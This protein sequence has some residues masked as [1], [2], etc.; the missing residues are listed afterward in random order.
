MI[1]GASP[2]AGSSLASRRMLSIRT[3]TPLYAGGF[4]GAGG[5]ARKGARIGK[6]L[7]SASPHDDW[8][9]GQG[10]RDLIHQNNNALI[11][12]LLGMAASGALQ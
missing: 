9:D 2:L 10:E 12:V 7:P 6:T 5:G 1:L 3:M 4:G 11:Y 8:D